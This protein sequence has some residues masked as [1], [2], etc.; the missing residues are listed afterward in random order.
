MKDL[1]LCQFIGRMGNS[2]DVRYLPDGKAVA[3]FSIACS[4]DYKKD[5]QKVEQ[6]NWIRV[7][8]FGRLAEIIRD[9]TDK[10]SQV[11]L[12][13]K[14]VTRKWQNKEGQDQYTTEIIAN[15][16]QMLGGRNSGSEPPQQQSAPQQ[17]SNDLPP[18]DDFDDDIPFMRLPSDVYF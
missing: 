6:T 16:L 1:N 14:Q 17:Q 11:Y 8:A 4:D 5:G 7:V 10:G 13:G 3:N 9:Y 12:S 18:G 2:A 15:E